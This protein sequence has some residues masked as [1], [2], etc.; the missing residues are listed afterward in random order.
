MARIARLRAAAPTAGPTAAPSATSQVFED[1]ERLMHDTGYD[2]DPRDYAELQTPH[3]PGPAR[4]HDRRR[5]RVRRREAGP[6]AHL[7]GHRH[8]PRRPRNFAERS[9]ATRRR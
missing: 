1:F 9:G 7:I 8:F 5:S 3:D 6:T 4:L 2:P